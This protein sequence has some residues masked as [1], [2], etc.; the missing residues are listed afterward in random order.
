[1]QLFKDA[2]ADTELSMRRSSVKPGGGVF[3]LQTEQMLWA[4]LIIECGYV[5]IVALGIF[6]GGIKKEVTLF[7][8]AEFT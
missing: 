6:G 7:V 5:Q 1:M 3:R 8:V 2:Y 4:D